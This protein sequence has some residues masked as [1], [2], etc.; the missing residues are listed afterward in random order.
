MNKTQTHIIYEC[1]ICSGVHSWDFDGDCRSDANRFTC[2]EDYAERNG[3]SIWDLD[4]RT[5]GD[6][7]EADR[8]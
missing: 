2:P 8:K 4:I 6:R 5:M 7:V 3:L 1:G